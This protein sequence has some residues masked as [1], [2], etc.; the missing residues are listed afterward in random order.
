MRRWLVAATILLIVYCVSFGCWSRIAL[1]RCEEYGLEG[2]CFLF[3]YG[4]RMFIDEHVRSEDRVRRFY[5]PL[6]VV[7]EIVFGEGPAPPPTPR[8]D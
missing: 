8:L 6:T 1:A 2:Y 3:W 7:D 5:L 4:D